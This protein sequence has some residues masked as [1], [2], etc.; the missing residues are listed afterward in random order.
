MQSA[1]RSLISTCATAQLCDT[2]ANKPAG[3]VHVHAHVQVTVV[4]GV[5]LLHGV[6]ASVDPIRVCVWV[7][8]AA[9]SHWK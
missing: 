6:M 5:C 1:V 8:A 7:S 3:L 2:A 4:P 9:S